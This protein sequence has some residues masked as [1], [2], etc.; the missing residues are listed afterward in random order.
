VI[1]L[2]ALGSALLARGVDDEDASISSSIF[3]SKKFKI[4]TVENFGELERAD[5]SEGIAEALD[6]GMS[7][8]AKIKI[9]GLW[10]SVQAAAVAPPHPPSLPEIPRALRLEAAR[11]EVGGVTLGEGNFA[12]VLEA[13]YDLG[14][15]LG[16]KRFAFKR[17]HA[18]VRFNYIYMLSQLIDFQYVSY[19]CTAFILCLYRLNSS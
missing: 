17:L 9:I 4:T 7:K 11:L 13:T 12:T 5:V 10:E 15:R 19:P 6:A 16:R 1:E 2:T 14:G 3:A 8:S 18:G